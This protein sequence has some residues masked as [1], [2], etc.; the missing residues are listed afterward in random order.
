MDYIIDIRFHHDG[1]G[2]LLPRPPEVALDLIFHRSKRIFG[3]DLAVLQ[4]DASGL[5][6]V[7]SALSR[8]DVLLIVKGLSEVED[9]VLEDDGGVAEDEVDCT[10]DDAASVELAVGLDVESVLETFE[11]TVHE[12]GPI[13]LDP[14]GNGLVLLWACCVSE[15]HCFTQESIS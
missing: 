13:G 11:T 2:E 8:D 5:A 1:S 7:G 9:A 10:G 4:H 14:C 15:A 12:H 3:F 6:L